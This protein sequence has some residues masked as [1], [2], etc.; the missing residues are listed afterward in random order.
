MDPAPPS[1][2]RVWHWLLL[3]TPA[4]EM[5]AV[6]MFVKDHAQQGFAFAVLFYNLVAAALLCLVLGLWWMWREPDVDTRI[7]KA[8]LAGVAIAIGNGVILFAGCGIAAK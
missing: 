3:L 2:R 1:A 6:F 8:I 7:A 4:V 5:L